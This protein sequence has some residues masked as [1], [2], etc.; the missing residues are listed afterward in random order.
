MAAWVGAYLFAIYAMNRHERGLCPDCLAALPLNPSE[1][2]ERKRS[3]LRIACATAVSSVAVV[4]G[5][6]ID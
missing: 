3:W 5:E 1:E 6:F 4:W 2:V